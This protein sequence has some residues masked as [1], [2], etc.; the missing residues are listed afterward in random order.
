MFYIR[1][2][3]TIPGAGSAIHIAELEEIDASSC[4]MLR[5]IALGPNDAIVGLATPQRTAGA[6]QAPQ[7][8]VPH[9]DTYNQFE[10]ISAKAINATEFNALW[11]EAVA[12]FPAF[13]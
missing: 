5:L 7:E 1:T 10:G 11:S 2:T 4:R 8:I 9:P 12:L 6:A 3:L 13:E